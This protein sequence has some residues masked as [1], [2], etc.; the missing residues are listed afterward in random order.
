M[1]VGR[2]GS[3]RAESNPGFG[4]CGVAV[5]FVTPDTAH[6]LADLNV[7]YALQMKALP[8]GAVTL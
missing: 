8:D 3:R 5:N 2:A 1:R 6:V 4:R 7:F